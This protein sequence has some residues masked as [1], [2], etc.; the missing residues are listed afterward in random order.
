MRTL[1]WG[2]QFNIKASQALEMHTATHLTDPQHEGSHS[3]ALNFRIK[4]HMLKHIINEDQMATKKS[5]AQHASESISRL[6]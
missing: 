2:T 6:I 4:S 3:G 1:L 5:S